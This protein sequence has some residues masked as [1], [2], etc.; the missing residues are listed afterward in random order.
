[1]EDRGGEGRKGSMKCEREGRKG[2]S[3]GEGVAG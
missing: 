1:M 3:E 2:E